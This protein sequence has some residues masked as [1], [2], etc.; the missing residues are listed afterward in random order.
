MLT[1]KVKLRRKSLTRP[2]KG[3]SWRKQLARIP[4]RL[5]CTWRKSVSPISKLVVA[6]QLYSKR[7]G[8]ERIWE[9]AIS[10]KKRLLL[11][12][13]AEGL[14]RKALRGVSGDHHPLS[15]G[16]RVTHWNGSVAFRRLKVLQTI[17]C[18]SIRC[19]KVSTSLCSP[20]VSHVEFGPTFNLV[21]P[22]RRT[23]SYSRK[24]VANM[25]FLNTA[26]LASFLLPLR[27]LTSKDLSD[28]GWPP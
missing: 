9:V 6:Y 25:S 20:D 27:A 8:V 14:F 23:Q 2:P 17:V 26:V 13:H 19:R 16:P 11:A 24:D 15:H 5:L 3:T 28:S 18:S 21:Y 12:V 10:T 1:L 4:G 22:L 7:A